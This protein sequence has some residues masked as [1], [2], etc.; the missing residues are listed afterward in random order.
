MKADPIDRLILE[1]ARLPGIGERSAARLA[2]SILK[3]SQGNGPSL[4][5]DLASALDSVAVRGSWPLIFCR[6]LSGIQI[7][8]SAGVPDGARTPVTT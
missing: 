2:Y 4:A 5:K 6:P 1:L 8:R 3:R 7:T